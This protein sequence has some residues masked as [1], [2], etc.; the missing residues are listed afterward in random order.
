MV[1]RSTL[2]ALALATLLASA[3]CT[4]LGGNQNEQRN[5]NVTDERQRS[6]GEGATVAVGGRGSVTAEPDA[7]T[8]SGNRRK[9]LGG[10][11]HWTGI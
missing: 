9:V 6:G 11:R 10:S 3:G 5:S 4:G 2:A 1:Q 8:A 7:A